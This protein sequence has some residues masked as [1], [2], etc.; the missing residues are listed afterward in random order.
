MCNPKGL[1]LVIVNYNTPNETINCMR[2]FIDSVEKYQVPYEVIVVDNR[3]TDTSLSVLTPVPNINLICALENRGYGV[4]L[5]LGANAARYDLLILSNSDIIFPESFCNEMLTF[6]D[7]EKADCLGVKLSS[8]NG[9]EQRSTF[10]EPTMMMFIKEYFNPFS[11]RWLDPVAPT[12]VEGIVGA[13][14]I[15]KS[16]VYQSVNGFDPYF[17]LYSEEVDFCRRVRYQGYGIWYTPYIQ[18]IHLGGQ[19]TKGMSRFSFAELHRSRFKYFLKFGSRK[20]AILLWFFTILS[21]PLD[22]AK[23][24]FKVLVGKETL[25]GMKSRLSGF[26]DVAVYIKNL[27]DL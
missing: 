16:E 17:F 4:A 13:L 11:K 22:A 1:S 2:S 12:I 20:L 3:S 15:V 18:V 19:S 25:S 26:Y 24:A 10:N 5:N 9:V 21:F 23:S 6:I 27:R 8:M 7:Q 14:I